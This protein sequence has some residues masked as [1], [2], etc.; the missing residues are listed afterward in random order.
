MFFRFAS[1]FTCILSVA[2]EIG[3]Y[4]ILE[5]KSLDS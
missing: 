4:I 1:W 3:I 2:L 5:A